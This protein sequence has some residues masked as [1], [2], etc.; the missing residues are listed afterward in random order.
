M[1]ELGMNTQVRVNMCVSTL[2][3]IWMD[4]WMDVVWTEGLTQAK[5]WER[6]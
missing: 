2:S 5:E 6:S 4:G 3:V 1:D